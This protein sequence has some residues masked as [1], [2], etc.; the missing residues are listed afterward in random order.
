MGVRVIRHGLIVGSGIQGGSYYGI[1]GGDYE[2]VTE[3]KE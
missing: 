2:V 3:E 1:D